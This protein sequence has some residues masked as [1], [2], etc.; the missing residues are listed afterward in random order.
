[1]G[2]R[3]LSPTSPGRA[4][5]MPSIACSKKQVIK[6]NLRFEI[7]TTDA[8]RRLVAR[9][10]F[11]SLHWAAGLSTTPHIATLLLE[12]GADLEAL[13]DRGLTP[14]HTAAAYGIPTM[15][16]MLIDAGAELE[17]RSDIGFTPLHA[18]A[19]YNRLPRVVAVLLEAGA[20][21]EA[22]NGLGMTPLITAAGFSET[23]AVVTALLEAGADPWA[24]NNNGVTARDAI[25]DNPRLKDTAPFR[26]IMGL[27]PVVD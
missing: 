13:T 17:A 4:F 27:E 5:A 7:R 20:D 1:M 6:R 21:L 11:T 18:A 12:T 15:V 23:P 24:E 10:E 25:E 8:I 14:L 16:K 9:G 2:A 3:A 26:H 22:R 19:A